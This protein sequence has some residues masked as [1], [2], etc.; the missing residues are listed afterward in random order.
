MRRSRAF[1]YDERIINR[2]P[3][4][5]HDEFPGIAPHTGPKNTTQSRRRRGAAARL[6]IQRRAEYDNRSA[7]ISEM[8]A[9]SERLP[10][11]ALFLKLDVATVR[12]ILDREEFKARD[13]QSQGRPSPM[14][15]TRSDLLQAC[16]RLVDLLDAPAEI[17]LKKRA[18]SES[19]ALS[20]RQ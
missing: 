7:S 8:V 2:T 10:L 18:A 3:D 14:G 13:G 6:W 12:E 1:V 4:G 19:A 9:A 5:E 15:Q 20:E 17:P 16:I 11:L